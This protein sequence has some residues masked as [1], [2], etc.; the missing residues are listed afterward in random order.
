VYFR[1]KTSGVRQ[2]LQ[3]V[4][5]YRDGRSV[6]QR[7]IATL[8]RLDQLAASGQLESLLASGAKFSANVS[9]LGEHR[10]G[11]LEELWTRSIGPGLLFGRLW[12]ETGIQASLQELLRRRWFKF[13]VE[14]AV[15][16]TV[17]HRLLDPGSDRAAE[18]WRRDFVMEGVDALELQHLYRA[19]AWLGQELLE[20]A[21]DGNTAFSPRCTKDLIEESLY[22]RRRD[23]FSKLVVAFF[24]TTSIYFEGAGGET[25]GRRGNSKDHRPDLRQMVV[26]LVLDGEGRPLCCELWPGNTTDVKTLLPVLERLE[27]RFEISGVCVVADRGMISEETLLGLEQRKE[28]SQVTYIL[29][30]KLRKQKEVSAEVLRRAGR[31][32]EVQGARH[33][34]TDPAPLRVKEVWVEGR[35]YV[36]CFNPERAASDAAKREKIVAGLREALRQSDKSLV[37]NKGFRLY[38]KNT[39]PKFEVDEERI[40]KE[41]KLDGKWV[42]RTNSDLPAGEVALTYKQLWMVESLFRSVKSVLH[43]R[44][45]YHRSDEAIRGHVFCSFLALLLMRELQDRMDKRGWNG[46]EWTDVIRDLQS[47][48]QTAVQASDGKRFLIRSEIKGWCG[49][50]FQASGVAMPATVRI[51]EAEVTTQS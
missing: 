49:K 11:K 50:A 10:S 25:L 1:V 9:L 30:A 36:L 46:A 6:K 4:E 48:S 19:M 31:Y 8:G 32:H 39:G 37:G 2:Y 45:I 7:I 15:F 12:K 51:M 41:A 33:R 34:S 29:G 43:T 44:P 38:L 26:G 47:L 16:L 13:D 27:K 42:L 35:R 28:H 23:L 17:V 20:A 21:Q 3:I 40:A 18:K 14:A 24:D 22:A 5:G